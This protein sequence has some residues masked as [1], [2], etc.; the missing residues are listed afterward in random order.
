MENTSLD[1]PFKSIE[2][3]EIQ[4]RDNPDEINNYI[5][6]S[7][8]NSLIGDYLSA[9]KYLRRAGYIEPDNSNVMLLTAKNTM[10]KGDVFNGL[11]MYSE[12]LEF[13]PE[14]LDVWIEAGKVAAWTG[15][16]DEAID[17]LKGGLKQ[18]PENFNILANLGITSLWSGEINRAQEYFKKAEEIAGDDIEKYKDLGKIYM[19]NLFPEKAIETYTKAINKDNTHLELYFLLE[20]AYLQNNDRE[21]IPRLRETIA[22]TFNESPE[23]IKVVTTF[24]NKQNMKEKV[25]EE[26]EEQLKVQ[27]DNL[28]LRKTL[29]E[30]YFWNGDR[31]R[32]INEYLNILVNY[33]YRNILETEK[34]SLEFLQLLDRSYAY[35]NFLSRMPSYIASSQNEI[36]K[37]YSE[38][39]TEKKNL[40]TLKSSN[41]KAKE[42]GETVNSEG[43]T[44][45]MIKVDELETKL[46][47]LLAAKEI[48]VEKFKG[49]W[50]KVQVLDSE[51]L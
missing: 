44:N 45:L 23:Y 14:R 6:I 38:Y 3:Y 27:P 22:K 39:N 42:K 2:D 41:E 34:Q 50:A 36:S 30:I 46:A 24:E 16:Y 15:K 37:T 31:K 26:Y 10:W 1:N 4:I 5:E 33:T 9:L 43:E 17:F 48:F 21:K 25:I 8:V 12:L 49:L 20:E 47:S 32:S 35:L 11:D 13:L 40:N 51:L 18:D 19:A 7:L 29:A 28:D